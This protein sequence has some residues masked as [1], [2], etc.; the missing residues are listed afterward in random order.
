MQTEIQ[1]PHLNSLISF[2]IYCRGQKCPHASYYA[3]KGNIWNNT[4]V[5][6]RL[7]FKYKLKQMN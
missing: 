4:F 3:N 2:G 6:N 1:E 5:L 7:V